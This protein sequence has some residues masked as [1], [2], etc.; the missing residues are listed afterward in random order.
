[1]LYSK[2]HYY[3]LIYKSFKLFRQNK[4]PEDMPRWFIKSI[5]RF[6]EFYYKEPRD[7]QDAVHLIADQLF[8][9]IAKFHSEFEI[10]KY[11]REMECELISTSTTF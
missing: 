9:P 5:K 11:I 4:K 6:T 2:W 3:P 8:T 1:M 7:D 10:K